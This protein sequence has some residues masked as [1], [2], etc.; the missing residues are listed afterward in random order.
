MDALA[1]HGATMDFI[2]PEP[3]KWQILDYGRASKDAETV[4]YTLKLNW[5]L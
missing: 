1:K 5:A 2:G 4:S 3:V